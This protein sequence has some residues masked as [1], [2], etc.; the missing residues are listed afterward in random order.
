LR[1][2]AHVLQ[3]PVQDLHHATNGGP[4]ALAP[5]TATPAGSSR[6]RPSHSRAAAAGARGSPPPLLVEWEKGG[7]LKNEVRVRRKQ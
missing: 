2:V 7:K 6:R 4:G 3:V 5:P 1:E